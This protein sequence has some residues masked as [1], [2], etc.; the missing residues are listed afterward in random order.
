[1]SWK[2]LVLAVIG[3]GPD[4]SQVQHTCGVPGY[5]TLYDSSNSVDCIAAARRVA[6][7]NVLL[8]S[9]G[10]SDPVE[11]ARLVSC[12]TLYVEKTDS[13]ETSYGLVDGT[14]YIGD[15]IRLA[16]N[17][18]A[19]VHEELH[20]IQILRLQGNTTFHAGWKNNGYY[21]LDS[22]YRYM[23]DGTFSSSQADPGD[24]EPDRFTDTQIQNLRNAQLP[25]DPWL[26]FQSR[27]YTICK[28]TP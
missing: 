9:S 8:I 25:I 13:W 26:T 1:M 6:L 21:A 4:L 11:Y 12:T 19:L 20:G 24:C 3:C 15:G 28:S 22:F 7:G 27:V 17:M 18:W 23:L 2:I 16:P 10:I 14:N 5:G